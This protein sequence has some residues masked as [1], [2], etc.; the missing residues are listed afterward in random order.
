[1]LELN[2]QFFGEIIILLLELMLLIQTI[3]LQN[4]KPFE[5]NLY[6]LLFFFATLENL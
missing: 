2:S 6:H 1:M 4:M 5:R 3:H